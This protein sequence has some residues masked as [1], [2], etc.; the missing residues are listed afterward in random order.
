MET[1][2]TPTA[3]HLLQLAAIVS[4]GLVAGLLYGYDCSILNSFT[5]LSDEV[6]LRSFQAINR[7]IQNGYFFTSFMGSLLLLPVA[8]WYSR[9]P[10]NQATFYLFIIA[11]LLYFFGVF[12]VTAFGNVP[13]NN[14]LDKLDMATASPSDMARM[15]GLFEKSWNSYHQLRTIAAI[16]SFSIAALAVIKQKI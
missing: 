5:H 12:G 4:T 1:T 8:A 6:Y 16:L 3:M 9:Q 14:A 10:L 2:I 7:G 13:L 15:R 11:T